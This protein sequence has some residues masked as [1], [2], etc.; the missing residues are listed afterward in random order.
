MKK[1]ECKLVHL[2]DSA[3]LEVGLAAASRARIPLRIISHRKETEKPPGMIL[4]PRTLEELNLIIVTASKISRFL[5]DRGVDSELIRTI[6]LGSDYAPFSQPVDRTFLRRDL[7][8]SSQDFLV[9]IM[10]DLKDPHIMPRMARAAAA[11]RRKNSRIYPIL[12]GEG[13][14]QLKQEDLIPGIEHLTFYLGFGD[15]YPN[16]LPSLDLMLFPF[17]TEGFE[18]LIRDALARRIPLGVAR[19]EGLPEE[20]TDRKTA[21]LLSS[22][23][24]TSIANAVL[25]AYENKE[26][27][28]QLAENSYAMMFEKYSSEAMAARIVTEYERLARR[29]NISLA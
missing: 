2:H 22:Q 3:S 6:P 9:G 14:V 21:L 11:M 4:R 25:D 18:A 13:E 23:N 28:R 1:L 15:A 8:L 7:H 5:R 10:T 16:V 29:R 20:L 12:L 27:V 26:M 24:L 17:V 19:G